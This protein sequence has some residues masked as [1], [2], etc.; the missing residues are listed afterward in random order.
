MQ[1]DASA[2]PPAATGCCDDTA[3]RTEATPGPGSR[4]A[5]ADDRPDAGPPES[6]RFF[7]AT[8]DQAVI[9]IA[10]LSPEGRWLRVNRRLCDLLGY[11]PEEL[12]ARTFQDLTHP[13][14]LAAD[15][16]NVGR[17]LAGEIEEYELDKRYVRQD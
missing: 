4:P 15:L 7:R 5:R 13:D 17:L 1:P 8:F 3:R 9:G 6:E 2:G 16:A 10:H 12:A 11:G 14:D